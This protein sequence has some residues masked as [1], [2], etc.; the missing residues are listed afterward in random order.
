VTAALLLAG[1]LLAPPAAAQPSDVGMSRQKSGIEGAPEGFGVGIQ[2]G[3]PTGL[4]FA[5]RAGEWSNI[6]A[7]VGWSFS[8]GRLHLAADYTRNLF[9][10]RPEETENVRYPFYV[11]AGG[12]L[13]V[14]AN[15][16]IPNNA[17][18]GRLDKNSFGVRFPVGFAILPTEQAIDVF[19]EFAPVMLVIPDTTFGWDA[20]LGFRIFFGGREKEGS[21]DK[22][23]IKLNVD[24]PTRE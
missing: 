22:K 3:V 8:R 10:I 21:S 1:A 15:D 13:L 23:D 5:Y 6:Q 11:G 14:G 18:S 2:V 24:R 9:I 7:G 20:A 12:R 17:N 16:D 4:S 19:L